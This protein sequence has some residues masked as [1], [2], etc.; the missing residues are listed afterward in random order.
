MSADK[1]GRPYFNGAAEPIR[2]S[3][4]DSAKTGEMIV[5]PLQWSCG[6]NPQI[7]EGWIG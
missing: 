6:A 4:I 1:A 7:N 5:L 2:R 3:T